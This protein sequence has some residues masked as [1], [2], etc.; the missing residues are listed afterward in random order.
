M[1]KEVV[2]F[3]MPF[4]AGRGL[5]D[6]RETRSRRTKK[7]SVKEVFIA[8]YMLYSRYVNPVTGKRCDILEA[9]D[10]LERRTRMEKH[11]GLSRCG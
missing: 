3:G 4:Y 7:R 9:L 1:D 6:D 8:A 2:C 10:Y 11:N 5:T